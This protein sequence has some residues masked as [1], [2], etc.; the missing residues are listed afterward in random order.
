MTYCLVANPITNFEIV[1]EGIWVPKDARDDD[2]PT[3]S[4]SNF[5]VHLKCGEALPFLV[6]LV[7]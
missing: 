4:I 2:I 5:G 3:C 7:P 6:L 1:G